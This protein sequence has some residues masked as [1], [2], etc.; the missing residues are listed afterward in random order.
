MTD[1]ITITGNIATVPELKYTG[2][3]VAVVNFRVASSQRRFDRQ[4]QSWVD[5]GTNWYSVSA[6]RRLADNAI[7]SLHRGERIVVTGRLRLRDWETTAKR[8]TT[9]EID[10]DAIGHDLLWGTS[11]F[12]RSAGAAEHDSG[13]LGAPGAEAAPRGGE[14][15]S[16]APLVGEHAAAGWATPLVDEPSTHAAM[17]DGEVRPD[18]QV[19]PVLAGSADTPF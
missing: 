3:G 1:T 16:G 7:K 8:G 9:A 18:S 5:A 4:S 17:P 12:A 2:S 19:E 10:A 11:V 13:D 15:W 6:F 14:Q